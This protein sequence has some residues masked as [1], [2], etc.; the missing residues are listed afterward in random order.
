MRGARLKKGYSRE[1]ANRRLRAIQIFS[2]VY[3]DY[4]CSREI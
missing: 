2:P 3:A 1:W 4:R